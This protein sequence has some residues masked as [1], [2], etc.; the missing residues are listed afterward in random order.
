MP[1]GAGDSKLRNQV[2]AALN[3]EALSLADL[4]VRMGKPWQQPLGRD[5]LDRLLQ[6]DTSFTHVSQGIAYLPALL[7]GTAWT[8]WVDPDDG[9]DEFVRLHP[10]L[11]PLGWWLIQGDVELIGEDGQRQGLLETKGWLLDGRDTD[12][13]LGPDGWLDGLPGNWARVEVTGGALRWTLLDGPPSATPAQAAALRLG[14]ERAVRD[15]EDTRSSTATPLPDGLV[16]ASGDGPIHEALLADSVAFRSTTIAPLT[17]LYTAAGLDVRDSLVAAEGFDWDALR[18]WQQR[19]RLAIFHGLNTAQ[20]DTLA[21]LIDALES[22]SAEPSQYQAQGDLLDDGAIAA[23]LWDEVTRHGEAAEALTG[24]AAPPAG[25]EGRSVGRAWLHARLLDRSGEAEAAIAELEAAVGTDCQHRPALLDLASLRADRGDAVGSLRLLVQAGVEP[26]A[27]ADEELDEL[28]EGE[29]LWDE[30]WGFAMHRPR[31]MARRNDL[32]PCGSGRKYKVCHLGRETHSLDDRAGWLY[33]KAIRF[34]RQRDGFAVERLAELVVGEDGPRSL[35]R[36]LRDGPFL[37]DVALH[38]EGVFEE[39]LTARDALLPDDEALLA[40]QWTLVDRS[41]F[42]VLETTGKQLVL[43]DIARGD[44]IQVVNTHPSDEVRVGTTLVGRPLPVGETFRAFSGFI[45]VDH[46]YQDTILAAIEAG[47]SEAIADAI[48]VMLAPPVL[49][50]TDGEDLVFHT[51]TWQVRHPDAVDAA[52]A[53]A[54]LQGDGDN[55]WSL[56]PRLH[57]P[58]QHRHRHRPCRR[59]RADGRSELGR[60]CHRAPTPRRAGDP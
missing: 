24:L 54:G 15:D 20:A 25:A 33:M 35:A 17:D 3:G 48:G 44:R 34:L 2:I 39:F 43:R 13:L 52:L 56:V 30:V 59:R 14:F 51:I 23:A 37:T 19:N 50:N 18:A 42:E 26:P 38:E 46:G 5:D 29:L 49:T 8:V 10:Y 53:Q 45:P 4:R 11:S 22:T 40:A 28:N 21:G 16:F 27:D 47:S 57:E 7:E 58:A 6:V 32:C 36:E 41:V 9:A 12:V 31:P 1:H 60:A 55:Q